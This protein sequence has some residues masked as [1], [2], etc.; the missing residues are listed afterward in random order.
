MLVS[1][2]L[3]R[4]PATAAPRN[5]PLGTTLRARIGPRSLT[6]HRKVPAMAQPA[7]GANLD[8]AL[9]IHLNVPTQITLYD[10][11]TLENVTDDADLGLR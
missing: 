6:T 8:K 3:L 9:D 10:V 4:T 2:L 5:G 1:L 11:L 7:V